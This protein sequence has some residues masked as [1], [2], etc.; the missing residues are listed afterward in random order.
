MLDIRKL[1]Q[2]YRKSIKQARGRSILIRYFGSVLLS[3][4][5]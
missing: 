3:I 5:E 2:N 1:S 4:M